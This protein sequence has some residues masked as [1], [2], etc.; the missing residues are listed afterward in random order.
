MPMNFLYAKE[1][2]EALQMIKTSGGEYNYV[3]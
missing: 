3:S 2:T 1:W